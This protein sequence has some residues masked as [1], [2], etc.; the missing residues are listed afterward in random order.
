M[1][2]MNHL[3]RVLLLCLPLTGSSGAEAEQI[4]EMTGFDIALGEFAG[5]LYY[6]PDADGYHVVA[7]VSFGDRAT[8]LRLIATLAEGQ[9]VVFSVPG[10]MG[11]P[12]RRLK[13]ARTGDRLLVTDGQ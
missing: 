7:T 6:V 13:V 9:S 3:A 4:R 10:K 8:P 2:A 5:V 12:E 1:A 11:E